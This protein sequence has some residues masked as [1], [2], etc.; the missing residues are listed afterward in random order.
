MV[1]RS[2]STQGGNAPGLYNATRAPSQRGGAASADAT[3]TAHYIAIY[4]LLPHKNICL[5]RREAKFA[6]N[7]DLGYVNADHH[8]SQVCGV[9]RRCF[10]AAI[11]RRCEGRQ[12][13]TGRSG[14]PCAPIQ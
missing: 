9:D 8:P 5:P 4:I 14:L 1:N 7:K 2:I 12:S 11:A 13:R 6:T 10:P 3:I